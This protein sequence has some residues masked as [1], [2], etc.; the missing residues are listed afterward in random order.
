MLVDL[1]SLVTLPQSEYTAGLAEVIKTGLIEDPEILRIIEDNPV[2][3]TSHGQPVKAWIRS[4]K[5]SSVPS[6]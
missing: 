2:L 6:L 5:S 4:R 1:D 3:G